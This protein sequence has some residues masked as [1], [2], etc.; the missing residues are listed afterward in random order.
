[1]SALVN[2]NTVRILVAYQ[3]NFL[4]YRILKSWVKCNVT[5]LEVSPLHHLSSEKQ[6]F[7]QLSV[8]TVYNDTN[9]LLVIHCIFQKVKIWHFLSLPCKLIWLIISL[10]NW[11]WKYMVHAYKCVPQAIIRYDINIYF[12]K[13]ANGSDLE[14][15]LS[16]FFIEK[17]WTVIMKAWC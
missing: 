14:T 5:R 4:A 10:C 17:T 11:Y 8:Y 2:L 7:E 16:K 13:Q 12:S 1:M 3:W 6:Q 9:I 15:W